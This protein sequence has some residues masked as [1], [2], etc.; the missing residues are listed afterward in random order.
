MG[1]KALP[2]YPLVKFRDVMNGYALVKAHHPDM[3]LPDYVYDINTDPDAIDFGSTDMDRITALIMSLDFNLISSEDS[4]TAPDSI[5]EDES[6]DVNNQPEDTI[7]ESEEEESEV[8]PDEGVLQVDEQQLLQETAIDMLIPISDLDMDVENDSEAVDTTDVN[9]GGVIYGIVQLPIYES[10]YVFDL[11]MYPERLWENDNLPDPRLYGIDVQLLRHWHIQDQVGNKDLQ[12][13]TY[14]SFLRYLQEIEPD[15][16]ARCI[17]HARVKYTT[18][19]VKQHLPTAMKVATADSTPMLFFHDTYPL[20][21]NPQIR[22]LQIRRALNK[23]VIRLETLIE[24]KIMDDV[25][26]N[27][28][29]G[30]FTWIPSPKKAWLRWLRWK[31]Y[32]LHLTVVSLLTAMPTQELES[33]S[34]G[35]PMIRTIDRQRMA[36][37][38]CFY[39]DSDTAQYRCLAGCL[40]VYDERPP[41][42]DVAADKVVIIQD[43]NIWSY[44]NSEY[45][46]AISWPN[47]TNGYCTTKSWQARRLN[48]YIDMLNP[49]WGRWTGVLPILDDNSW[50]TV[51]HYDDSELPEETIYPRDET[52]ESSS[53]PLAKKPKSK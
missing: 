4:A 1:S 14:H 32:Y 2:E 6:S 25:T 30:T 13:R 24:N 8:D 7:Y 34:E 20:S 18:T 35:P 17:E 50:A 49:K 37:H 44:G 9:N 41:I 21:L 28:F 12:D 43:I 53:E 38:N 23:F 16:L 10:P 29:W 42:T 48:D 19:T 52:N 40:G 26:D 31:K 46:E 3:E 27:V 5:Q 36:S 51:Q 47:K 33:H 45:V 11:H 15:Y 39:L 22:S